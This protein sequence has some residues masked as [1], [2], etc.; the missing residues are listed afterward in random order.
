MRTL[1]ALMLVVCMLTGCSLK[2]D[3]QDLD[4]QAEKI[5][6]LRKDVQ[7]NPQHNTAQ[8]QLGVLLRG[9]GEYGEAQQYLEAAAKDPAV[10]IQAQ[11]ALAMIDYE[12]GLYDQARE[13]LEKIR[14]DNPEF[15][16]PD[17]YYHIGR[18]DLREGKTQAAVE[19][20]R[21]AIA[22]GYT[23]RKIDFLLGDTLF[24]KGDFAEAAEALKKYLEQNPEATIV[25]L[26]LGK[27]LDSLGKKEEAQRE[28][29]KLKD[30]MPWLRQA[31]LSVSEHYRFHD[32]NEC[33]V[34]GAIKNFSIIKLSDVRVEVRLLDAQGQ[35][36][37]EKSDFVSPRNL[38][39]S[40]EGIFEF[41]FPFD[42]R[43]KS[44]DIKGAGR[45][46]QEF[47]DQELEWLDRVS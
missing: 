15:P 33:V 42:G 31:N 18:I 38:S 32:G 3:A 2:K 9:N 41:R 1:L 10:G 13:A 25:R 14:R 37:E 6:A 7:A 34:R 8:Y 26:Y 17:V 46:P 45:I 22:L 27:A 29:R 39:P 20:L 47:L 40:Q 36:L 21:K 24:R 35:V 43:V 16:F 44:H 5:Q 4:P 23:D 12:K 19:S 28:F 11:F 30:N